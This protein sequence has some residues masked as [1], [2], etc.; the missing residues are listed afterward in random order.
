MDDDKEH[1]VSFKYERLLNLCY[2]CGRLTHIDKDCEKWFESEGSLQPEDQQFGAWLRALPFV[3]ACKNVVAV[4]GFFAKKKMASSAQ[5][6]PASPSHPN[7]RNLPLV[8]ESG[9]NRPTTINALCANMGSHTIHGG[10]TAVSA[11]S[12]LTDADAV[13]KPT[14]QKD[15]EHLIREIDKDINLFECG[16]VQDGPSDVN[17]RE[18]L[19]EGESQP[20][21][22]SNPNTEQTQIQPIQPTIVYDITKQDPQT[23]STRAQEGKKWT[24]I[25]RPPIFSE[26]QDS[27][28]IIGKRSPPS[29]PEY[30]SPTKRRAIEAPLSDENPIPTAAADHQPRRQQ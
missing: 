12:D 11:N 23:H 21:I 19:A 26:L 8:S 2:W 17:G 27:S 10:T 6:A 16:K 4:P 18:H 20:F 29:L 5:N 7:E 28:P 24:R 22:Y 9:N 14:P 3:A 25:L 15:F 30:N 1:W 13:Q